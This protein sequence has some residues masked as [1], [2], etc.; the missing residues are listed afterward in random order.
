VLG[1]EPDHVVVATGSRSPAPPPGTLSATEV[2]AGPATVGHRV[3]V[4]SAGGHPWELDEV[5]EQLVA[6]DHEVVVAVAAGGL[7]GRGTDYGLAA[8]L[9]A[10]RVEV[11]TWAAPTGEWS[12]GPAGIEVTFRHPVTGDTWTEAGFDD[13][14]V[15]TNRQA[16]D[17][18]ARA[19]AGQVAVQVVGDALA[20]RTVRDAVWEARAAARRVGTDEV[21]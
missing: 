14:V 15:A 12:R 21:R 1:L 17:G 18:L 20:P 7:A 11:R 13:L 5:A 3:L 8:R 6:R 10:G 4:W 2:L 19:L 9:A 16:D